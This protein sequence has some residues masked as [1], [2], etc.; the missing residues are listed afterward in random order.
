MKNDNK[1]MHTMKLTAIA[2][3]CLMTFGAHAYSAEHDGYAI[4]LGNSATIGAMMRAQNRDGKLIGIA[5]GGS[6]NSTNKDDGDLA[7][8]RGDIVSSVAK[9]TSDLKL[10]KGDFGIFARASGFFNMSLDNKDDFFTNGRDYSPYCDTAPACGKEASTAERDRKNKQVQDQVGKKIELLDAY[11]YGNTPILDRTFSF[12]IGRQVLNW[13][14]STFVLNGINSMVAF[15]ANRARVSGF[16]LSEA[17]IPTPMVWAS[18]GLTEQ[19]SIEGFYQLSWQ[20][21]II[22]ASGTFFSTNDFAGIGGNRANLGFGEFPENTPTTSVQRAVDRTPGSSGQYGAAYHAFL[23][24][25]HESDIGLYAM[26]YHSRLPVYSGIS[27]ALPITPAGT[28]DP[29]AAASASYFAEFPKNIHLYGLSF[30]TAI[31]WGLSLQGEYSL[32][33]GQPIQVD[34]VE[35]LLAGLGAPSQIAGNQPG[36]TTGNKYL[37]GYRRKDIS[38]VDFGLTK[39]FS[40]S[41]FFGYDQIIG[42]FEIAGMRVHGLEDNDELRYDGPATDTP[43]NAAIANSV[44]ASYSQ[45]ASMLAGQPVSLTIPQQKGG[46]ATSNSWGYNFLARFSYE[47]VLDT[48]T[49]TPTVRFVHDVKGNSPKPVANYVEGRKQVSLSFGFRFRNEISTEIGYTNYFGGGKENLLADRDFVDAS[50]KYSF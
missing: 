37:R 33:Q 6:S 14:E 45:L 17:I 24:W 13:G 43:G 35:L 25:L 1:T 22:D 39:L 38:Q 9:I 27:T 10:S 23:P 48:F 34:T 31:P 16:E 15:N 8:D 19:T 47:N 26:N 36:V 49:L 18:I 12:K 5:N 3:G 40:P 2:C 4:E 20:K 7:F 32:K 41:K 42:A 21:T 44:S 30:N 28:P 29:Y 46:Y 50:V 11:I